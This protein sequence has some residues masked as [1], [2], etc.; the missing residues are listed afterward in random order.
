ML[1]LPAA[2]AAAAISWWLTRLFGGGPTGPLVLFAMLVLALLALFARRMR[3]QLVP[4][5]Q[6]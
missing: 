1:T 2:A 3:G 5:A 6:S 4:L